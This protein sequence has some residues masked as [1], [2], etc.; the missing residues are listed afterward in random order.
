MRDFSKSTYQRKKVAVNKV[1]IQ[2][3]PIAWGKYLRPL[4][5]IALGAAGV[6]LA[7]GIVFTAYRAVC[8]TTFFRLK[9]I[10]VSSAKH[11]TH[12][13]ILALGGVETGVICVNR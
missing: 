1:R 6:S 5:T 10:E 13:E 8:S 3:K 7:F 2:R 9:N 12:D 4:G 11:L